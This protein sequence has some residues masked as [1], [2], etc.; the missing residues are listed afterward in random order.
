M[1]PRNYSCSFWPG[2]QKFSGIIHCSIGPSIAITLAIIISQ[3]SVL[4]REA[5]G[6]FF[7]SVFL[8]NNKWS[9]TKARKVWFMRSSIEVALT[10]NEENVNVKFSVRWERVR[11]ISRSP[12][13]IK[14][15]LAV[16]RVPS[17]NRELYPVHYTMGFDQISDLSTQIPPTVDVRTLRF[18]AW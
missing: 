18:L 17:R 7:D 8:L 15:H 9:S 13:R 12:L 11:N 5:V 3:L 10:K 16:E 4:F 6:Q 2:L 1:V 14:A